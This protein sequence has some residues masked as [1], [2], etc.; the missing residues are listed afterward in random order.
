MCHQSFRGLVVTL[1]LVFANLI[2]PSRADDQATSRLIQEEIWALPLPLPR[3]ESF[4]AVFRPL[5]RGPDRPILTAMAD[6]PFRTSY[7][8]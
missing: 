1:L 3:A 2:T 4:R 8:C 7:Y 5:V 6:F